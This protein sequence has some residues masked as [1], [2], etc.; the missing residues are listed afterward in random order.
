MYAR[1]LSGGKR[2]TCLLSA[3]RSRLCVFYIQNVRSAPHH[4]LSFRQEKFISVSVEMRKGAPRISIFLQIYL[5]SNLPIQIYL[6]SNLPLLPKISK[7]SRR[8]CNPRA[9]F[10]KG[11]LREK[12]LEKVMG[13]G[14]VRIDCLEQAISVPRLVNL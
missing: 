11:K 6:L 5:L 4:S 14:L 3:H 13:G 2:K 8:S 1:D 9:R 7:S 12:L 10:E